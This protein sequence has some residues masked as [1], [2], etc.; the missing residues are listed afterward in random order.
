MPKQIVEVG[1]STI[2][3]QN[4]G[5]SKAEPETL[6]TVQNTI[7]KR[8]VTPATKFADL[9]P[10]RLTRYLPRNKFRVRISIFTTFQME[11]TMVSEEQFRVS[12]GDGGAENIA[13]V[14]DDVDLVEKV[15]AAA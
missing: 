12:V 3:Q 10:I 6:K 14:Q 1:G 11:T 15:K 7:A 8:S 5:K 13:T 2:V 4:G 9:V